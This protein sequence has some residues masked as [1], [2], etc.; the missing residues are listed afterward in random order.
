MIDIIWRIK[1]LNLQLAQVSQVSWFYFEVYIALCNPRAI[2]RNGRVIVSDQT[3][4]DVCTREKLF[5][6]ED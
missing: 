6:C 4:F 3:A 5:T 2:Q 1:D